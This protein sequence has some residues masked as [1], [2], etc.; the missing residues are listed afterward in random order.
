MFQPAVKEK[1]FSFTFEAALSMII[2]VII[3]SIPVQSEPGKL[4]KI[5]V[6]QKENDLIK[7]WVKEKEFNENEMKKDFREMFLSEK[8]EITVEGKK[9][10]ID[11]KTGNTIIKSS[12]FYYRNG[13]LDEI[14]VKV[15]V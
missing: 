1:G 6:L 3:I 13:K 10:G 4:E 2:L 12:G 5:Y 15:F 7:V 8:G 9:I 11:G 14:S